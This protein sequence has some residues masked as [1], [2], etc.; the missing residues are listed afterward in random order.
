V[1]SAIAVVK[2]VYC[3]FTCIG[4]SRLTVASCIS[5]SPVTC[6]LR[7]CTS[8][9]ALPT[10]VRPSLFTRLGLLYTIRMKGNF[11]YRIITHSLRGFMLKAIRP[12]VCLFLRPSVCMGIA[13]YIHHLRDCKLSRVVVRPKKS[14]VN[15]TKRFPYNRQEC[16]NQSS[17]KKAN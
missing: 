13:R 15:V 12:T 10:R 14:K 17:T 6:I 3:R 1:I 4:L 16:H 7:Q 11:S 9:T 2:G 8:I 5:T